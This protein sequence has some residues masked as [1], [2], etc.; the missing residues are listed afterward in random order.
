MERD[1]LVVDIT[2]S[3]HETRKATKGLLRLCATHLE[4]LWEELGRELRPGQLAQISALLKENSVDWG[5]IIGGLVGGDMNHIPFR[6]LQSPDNTAHKTA[7]IDLLDV[8][9]DLTPPVVDPKLGKHRKD[10]T[11]GRAKGST[12]G[13]HVFR[14]AGDRK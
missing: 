7:E 14:K 11:F 8:W 2:I 10:L 6:D 1:A 13:Y 3:H 4:S 12:W 9:E 5:P